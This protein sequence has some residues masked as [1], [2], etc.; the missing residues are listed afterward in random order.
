MF[1][2]ELCFFKNTLSRAVRGLASTKCGVLQSAAC[3]KR[4][5]SI[6]KL[7]FTIEELALI[8][9]GGAQH[10]VFGRREA[11]LSSA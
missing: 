11:S 10:A 3:D 5:F 7:R 9:H 6:A 8:A 1:L 4:E 2:R